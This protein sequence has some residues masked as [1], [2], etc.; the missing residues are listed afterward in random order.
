MKSILR[1]IVFAPLAL[2]FLFFAMANRAPVQV[3][4]DPLPGGDATGPSFEAP[5]YL[6]VLAS[7]ALGVLAGGLSSWV[8]HGRYRRAAR[9]AR[10]D[11]KVART[12]AEQLRGQALAS[13]SPD[14]ASGGRALRRNG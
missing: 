8:A 11:A 1:I 2:L 9:T 6:V 14:P 10:A 12:E 13:L 5:L 7:I 4:I 3:F